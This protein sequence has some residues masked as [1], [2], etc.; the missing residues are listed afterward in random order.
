MALFK[1]NREKTESASIK[2]VINTATIITKGTT[3]TGKIVGNDTIHIDGD[4]EGSI[5]VDNIVVI[6]KSGIVNGDIEAQKIIS[7]GI[8]NG[9]VKCDELEIMEP[10]IVKKR[11]NARKVQV[12]G[13]LEGDVVCDGLLIE[14][15]GFVEGRVQAKSII[16]AGSLIG[17]IACDLLSTKQTGYVKGSMYVSNISNE[18]GKVEGSI[19]Q[20]KE[21]FSDDEDSKTT[22]PPSELE[23]MLQ[24]S[25]TKPKK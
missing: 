12:R 7:S 18:G 22:N 14:P 25:T 5:E 8:I 23:E 6:G 9:N 3:I 15:K 11:V 10:S 21:L 4:I 1:S 17:D 2:E 19:G 24:E 13:K 20:Y 16:V